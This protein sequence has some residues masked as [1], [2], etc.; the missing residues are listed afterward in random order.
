MKVTFKTKK[1]NLFKKEDREDDFYE[2]EMPDQAQILE[3]E[4]EK[5]VSRIPVRYSIN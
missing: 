4:P 2:S 5:A 3:K 1:G